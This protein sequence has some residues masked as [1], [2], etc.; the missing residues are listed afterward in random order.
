MNTTKN[1]EHT[2]ARPREMEADDQ[3]CQYLNPY[4]VGVSNLLPVVLDRQVW[5][6]ATIG[7]QVKGD[8]PCQER[9][10]STSVRGGSLREPGGYV[11]LRQRGRTGHQK[12]PD[13][14][15]SPFSPP[16]TSIFRYIHH[17]PPTPGSPGPVRFPP[18]RRHHR[19]REGPVFILL[20]GGHC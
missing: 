6:Q 16:T 10:K 5:G 17:H 14:P 15:F 8:R 4:R 7:Q 11:G 2:C 12:A 19:Q 9:A 18:H 3:G 20:P 13:S 1:Y